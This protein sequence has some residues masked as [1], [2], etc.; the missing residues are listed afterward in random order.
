MNIE[1]E[2]SKDSNDLKCQ[3]ILS[4]GVKYFHHF[5]IQHFL[6]DIRYSPLFSDKV[7]FQNGL[8]DM[9]LVFRLVP[10]DAAL[11][12]QDPKPGGFTVKRIRLSVCRW[13][14]NRRGHDLG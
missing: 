1:Q 2:M 6:F 9:H 12:F 13:L 14:T 3:L 7:F 5:I 11:A 10:A 8:V 4:C